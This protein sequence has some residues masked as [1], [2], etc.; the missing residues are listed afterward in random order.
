MAKALLW[1][2]LCPVPH[3]H[4]PACAASK[5]LARG[6]AVFW[7]LMKETQREGAKGS[8]VGFC[9]CRRRD[10][11][12]VQRSY[13]GKMHGFEKMKPT[14]KQGRFSPCVLSSICADS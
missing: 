6:D 2:L 7:W 5:E 12:C 14:Q 3:C 10:G 8:W 13:Q 9:C 4:L 1:L 11:R